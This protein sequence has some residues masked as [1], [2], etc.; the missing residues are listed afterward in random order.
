VVSSTPGVGSRFSFALD[1]R[2]APAMP[3]EAGSAGAGEAAGAEQ[4][5]RSRHPGARILLVEDEWI[6]QEVGKALLEDVLGYAVDLAGDGHEAFAKV[7]DGHYDAVL[8]D[9]QMPVMDGLEATRAIRGQAGNRTT[10][11]LAMTANAF[12]EDRRA[13]EAAGMN[14]FIAKP[15]DPDALYRILLIWLGKPVTA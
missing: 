13:C 14:D 4:Q 6:N 10:P 5:L 2:K 8:M 3:Q 1:F 11:I 7:R 12:E 15:V 9:M